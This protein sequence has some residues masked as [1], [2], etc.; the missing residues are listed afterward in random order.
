M[1]M[2]VVEETVTMALNHFLPK[3]CILYADDNSLIPNCKNINGNSQ[4]NELHEA[5][6][7]NVF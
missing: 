1:K 5:K 6:A 7:K 3:K 2:L 4:N